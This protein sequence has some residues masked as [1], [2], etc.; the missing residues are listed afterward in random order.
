M[1]QGTF[2]L[3]GLIVVVLAVATF[4]YTQIS[5]GPLASPP[6]PNA[7]FGVIRETKSSF[8]PA[9]SYG[10]QGNQEKPVTPTP[11]QKQPP[12]KEE[13][14]KS[15]ISISP[16]NAR[17]RDIAA[18][19]IQISYSSRASEKI[20]ISNW[21]VSNMQGFSLRLGT[22]TNLPGTTQFVNQDQLLLIP[23]GKVNVISGRS[24]R[25]ENF[26]ANTCVAYFRQF[27]TFTP[28]ISSSCPSLRD[29]PGQGNF[30]DIC[31][32]Y[33]RGISSCKMNLSLPFNLD[34]NCR[35]YINKN[36]SYAG[37]V[38]NHKNDADFYKNEWWVYLNRTEPIWSD[39]RDTITLK[40][41]NGEVI[42]TYSY[43]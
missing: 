5:S 38:E 37:C 23:G 16:K 27:N 35:D 6:N 33:V 2:I 15:Y 14:L 32:Q 9:P 20:N 1:E 31:Y 28:S 24:P 25:G 19:Y 40:N 34:N 39:V 43:Q 4:S 30:S 22:A 3:F 11:T 13:L 29:E 21:S 18:E 12:T 26:R 8:R 42:Q 36:A 10:N 7:E 17:S 41:A